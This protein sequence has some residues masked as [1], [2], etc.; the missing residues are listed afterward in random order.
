MAHGVEEGIAGGAAAA[1]AAAEG[2][3]GADRLRRGVAARLSA[4]LGNILAAE[5]ERWA[6]WF[7]VG[8]GAGVALYFGLP[9]E[10]P[11]WL[12]PGIAAGCL[13]PLWLARR[14]LAPVVLLLGL[15]SVALGF[16]AAQLHTLGAAAPMLTRELGPVQLTGRVLA[17]ERQPTGARLMIGEL[18]VDRLAPEAT[19]AR[20]RLHLP[21]K[22][23]PPEAGT[24]VRLRAMLHPPASPAEPGAFDLQRRAYFE[25]FG[26]VGFVMGA[27]VAQE[28]PPPGGWRRVTV[29]F[30]QARAAIAER[31]RAAVADP[32]E[33]S[34][35]AALLNGEA[36]AIPESMMDAFRDSGLAHLLSISGLHVGIAAGIVFWVVR[37]LLALSPWMALRWPIKKIAALCGI[38]SAVLYT[39]LVGAPL[40]TLRSVLMTGLIMGAVIADR[41]PI[42]MRLVAFAGIVTILYDPEGML[43][44]SFQMSFAAVVALIAA[45]EL[46]TPWAV[47]QRRERGWIGRAALSLGGIAFSSVVATAATT[48]YGLYHFQQVAFYGVLSNMVAIPVTTVWIMPFSLL[49]Y[50]LLPFGLEGPAVV[51]MSWGVRLVIATAEQTAALP[52][53]TAIFPAMPDAAIAAVT[54]GGL[55]LAIWTGRWRWLGLAAVAGGLL[56]PVSAPRPD[57]LVSEDGRL[58]AVRSA[59]GNLSLSAA[60]DGRVADTWRRRDGME[61]PEDGAGQ[62]V[63]PLAGVSLDGRLR[64]DALGCLYR[65]QGKTVA[66]LRRPDAMP[67][68]CAVADAVVT[69]DPSRG[70][71]APL[72][73]DRWRLRREGAQ[74]LYLSDTGIRVESVRGQRGDR[75]WTTGGRIG[76]G[77]IGGGKVTGAEAGAR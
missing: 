64:C 52:G 18:T 8:A 24:V 45:F 5:R 39:L 32:A 63:W 31:V 73:I 11:V 60:S 41:S 37:A 2:E 25:G 76:G 1:A 69:A 50:L 48:P 56:G 7:P 3:G 15:L 16:A 13:P 21:A 19:P 74:A 54:L 57:V 22:V 4:A 67:E 65:A 42:S 28:A 47:R 68:D 58:M 27:P 12:G 36:A 40:P 46:A 14:H 43:G 53:A 10:P 38:L 6:L 55:W 75:P 72:V 44:P 71:R 29:A 61:R 77:R 35:T 66:L 30:E 59:E 34:V 9:T 49:S 17:V 26:A 51:A 70:C 62:D 20:V 33:S 23:A